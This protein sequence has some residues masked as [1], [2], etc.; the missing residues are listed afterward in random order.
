[1]NEKK[2]NTGIFHIGAKVVEETHSNHQ[3]L[4]NKYTMGT[5]VDLT[6]LGLCNEYSDYVTI[7]SFSFRHPS[8]PS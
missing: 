3:Q 4:F 2:S 1:M 6:V 8:F 7:N 5:L